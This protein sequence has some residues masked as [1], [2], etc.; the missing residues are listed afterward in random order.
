MKI[1]FSKKFDI[2]IITMICLNTLVLA[3]S[4]YD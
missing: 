2:F 4:W 3:I 1:V